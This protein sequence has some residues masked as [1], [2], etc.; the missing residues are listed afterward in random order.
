MFNRPM[1]T[2]SFIENMRISWTVTAR[3][4]LEATSLVVKINKDHQSLTSIPRVPDEI[5]VN[6]THL[7]L[8]DNK[9][10][11]VNAG[12]LSD[13]TELQKL[14]L[15]GNPITSFHH[16][17]LLSNTKLMQLFLD[18]TELTDPPQLSGA[19]DSVQE[20]RIV[21]A[22]LTEIPDNYFFGIPEMRKIY[23]GK[24][25][26]TTAKFGQADKLLRIELQ[27][28]LLTTMPEF[29]ATLQQL[30]HLLLQ[31]N[32]ITNIENDYFSRTPNLQYLSLEFNK[33]VSLINLCPNSVLTTMRLKNNCLAVFPNLTCSSQTLEIINLDFNALNFSKVYYEEFTFGRNFPQ[34]SH[35][36]SNVYS[37]K[38]SEND[39][40]E[41]SADFF[42]GFPNLETF[43]CT[44][45]TLKVFPNVSTLSK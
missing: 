16:D 36:F 7:N 4:I 20:L 21:K 3:L 6:T 14:V 2:I 28:N 40:N 30:T 27:E 19:K 10:A 11:A 41:F 45:C 33:I 22:D 25:K 32:S 34:E 9:I 29:R 24:N 23:L 1:K 31:K 37:L 15:T 43:D 13:L 8:K 38:M 35:I 18:G 17:A 26:L 12:D 42:D 44:G 5:P 39:I